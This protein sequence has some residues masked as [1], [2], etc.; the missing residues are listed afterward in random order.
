[1]I[2]LVLRRPAARRRHCRLLRA[3]AGS[4]LH[5][6]NQSLSTTPLLSLFFARP[7]APAWERAAGSPP[8]VEAGAAGIGGVFGIQFEAALQVKVVEMGERGC[9][10]RVRIIIEHLETKTSLP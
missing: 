10:V 4:F 1:L 7:R 2:P 6:G 8:A 5:G 9:I 3:H